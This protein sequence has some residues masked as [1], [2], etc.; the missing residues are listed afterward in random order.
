[1]ENSLLDYLSLQRFSNKE[2]NEIFLGFIEKSGFEIISKDIGLISEYVFRDDKDV[3]SIRVKLK[4]ISNSG[5]S[6]KPFIKRIQTTPL[7]DIELTKKNSCFMLIGI[8]YFCEKY[9][10]VS[11]DAARYKNFNTCRSAYVNVSAFDMA[12]KT[13]LFH[14]NDFGDNIYVCDEMHFRDLLLDYIDYTILEE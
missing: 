4:N 3:Y 2:L 6:N 1:M 8:T 14:C 10:L 13:G 11:W 7:N 5:W 12:N 9:F